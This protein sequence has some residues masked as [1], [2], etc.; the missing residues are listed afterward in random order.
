[1]KFGEQ[2]QEKLRARL[3][4]GHQDLVVGLAESRL[5]QSESPLADDMTNRMGFYAKGMVRGDW[6]VTAAYDTDK[7][8][9]TRRDEQIDPGQF[10]PLMGMAANS[11]MTP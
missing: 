5:G 1:M 2:R 6:L 10:Y 8:T 7:D 4:P 11:D 3:K 9:D